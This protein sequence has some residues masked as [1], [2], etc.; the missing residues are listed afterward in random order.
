M[1]ARE[2]VEINGRKVL[3]EERKVVDRRRATPHE[4][5]LQ[6][7]RYGHLATI[8]SSEERIEHHVFVYDAHAHQRNAG[9]IREVRPGLWM[10][11][12]RTARSRDQLLEMIVK[13]YS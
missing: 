2:I 13:V 9:V 11:N 5:A 6:M 12:F 1:P 3:I 7:A 10:W 8:Y 4:M